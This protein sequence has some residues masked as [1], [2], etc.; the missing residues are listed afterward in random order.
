MLTVS[1]ALSQTSD[2]LIAYPHCDNASLDARYLLQHVMGFSH[3]QLITR[4]QQ[5]LTEAQLAQLQTLVARRENGEPVAYLLGEWDFFGLQ[6]AVNE[7]V[8]VPRPETEQLVEWTLDAISAISQP[9]VC[10]L[11]TGTGAI[12]ISI[13][14]Q[15]PDAKLTAVDSSPEALAVA[16]NNCRENQTSNVQL[17][18]SDWLS[19]VDECFDCIVSNPPYIGGS[20]PELALLQHEPQS[21]L[22]AENHGLADIETIAQQAQSKL[23]PNGWLLFEHGHEQAEKVANTLMSLGYRDIQHRSDLSNTLR[24][25][26]ARA[27]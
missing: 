9:T 21:A 11:G 17:L 22:V 20:E 24:F 8:L 4:D 5:V 25:T 26:A 15:R 10:D 19:S 23:K 16:E 6:L 27:G 3:T 7:H 13:A 18:Q 14:H 12:A 1:A 2:K